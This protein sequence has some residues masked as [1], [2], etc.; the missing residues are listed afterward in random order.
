MLSKEWL[1][2]F[3]V[4]NI[5]C[6]SYDY[7]HLIK[8]TE[9]IKVLRISELATLS[10]FVYL[11]IFFLNRKLS[12]ESICSVT[13]LTVITLKLKL[14]GFLLTLLVGTSMGLK[15]VW[16]QYFHFYLSEEAKKKTRYI[17]FIQIFD[18]ISSKWQTKLPF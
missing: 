11:L 9:G 12:M 10:L 8:I 14:L 5:F 3:W 15:L 13:Q 16:N 4:E 1:F 6:F 17:K 18:G 7:S 2:T